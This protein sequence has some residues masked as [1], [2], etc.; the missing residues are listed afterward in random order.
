MAKIYNFF[1]RKRRSPFSLLNVTLTLILI[2]VVAYI[3]FMILIGSNVFSLDFVALKPANILQGE[4]LWTF[5]TSMFMHGGLGHL[6]INMFVLFSLGGTMERIIGKKR[7]L[8]FYLISGIFAGLLFVILAGLF[9]GSEV[10]AKIF[11]SPLIPAVG[12]SGAIFAIAGLFVI[13]TPRAKFTIIFF[14][15]F[16]LP[17]YIMIPLILMLTWIVSAASGFPIGNTAHFGGLIA[18]LA[19]GVYLKTKYKRKTRMIS[20]YFSR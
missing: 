15:F 10:G 4:Y 1:P 17:A 12:A 6:F 20:K 2:N 14:P 16:S 13:L 3:L 19:Y 18:G 8:W 9:G 5:I 7:F 11:G